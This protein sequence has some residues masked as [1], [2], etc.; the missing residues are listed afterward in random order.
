M[1]REEYSPYKAIHHLDKLAQM[2]KGEQP[3]P[4]QVQLIISD[5]CNHNCSFCAYRMEGYT[6]S[7][8]FGEWDDVKKKYDVVVTNAKKQ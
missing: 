4:A 7:Q 3:V 2:K 5:L 6:S 8:N 1:I